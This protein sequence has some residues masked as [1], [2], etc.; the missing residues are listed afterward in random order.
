MNL[1]VAQK[2]E[3][4]VVFELEPKQFHAL[5]GT[6]KYT[7]SKHTEA[8]CVYDFCNFKNYLVSLR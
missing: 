7:P 4:L 3:D 2:E 8:G 1:I 6:R 5:V